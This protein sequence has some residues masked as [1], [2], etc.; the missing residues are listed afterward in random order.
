GWRFIGLILVPY[1]V[2]VEV[3]ILHAICVYCTMMHVAIILDFVV[4][5]YL[6]FFGK[7]ALLNEG[8]AG[9]AEVPEQPSL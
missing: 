4:V 1:L 6:L 5:S 7:H 9:E 8:E 2:F 3:G